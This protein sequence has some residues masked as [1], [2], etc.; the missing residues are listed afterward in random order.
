MTIAILIGF[1]AGIT[2]IIYRGLYLGGTWGVAFSTIGSTIVAAL[3]VY[4]F[5]R[6]LVCLGSF[7]LRLILILLF[8][9]AIFSARDKL[10]NIFL[11]A[12]NTVSHSVSDI[13]NELSPKTR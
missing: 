13:V 5:L 1:F 12:T 8:I 4:I 7:F 10:M 11:G 9:G 6:I 3:V 2:L